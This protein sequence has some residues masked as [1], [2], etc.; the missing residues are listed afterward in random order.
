MK[1]Y[2]RLLKYVTVLT[3]SDESSSTVPSSDCQFHL[4]KLLVEEL[5]ELGVTDAHID[6]QCYVYGHLPATKG[7]ES[8]TSV[9]FIS[10]M[11]TVSDFCDHTITPVITKDYDG[12][13][14][15]LGTSGRVLD[16]KMFP[17]LA[18]LKGRT[19]ITSD[20]TTILGSDDKAGIAEI[21]T[22]L[23]SIIKNQIP[24]GPVSIAFTPDEEIGMGPAHFNVK[25]F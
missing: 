2:E 12:K 11:D 22:A 9:G 16:P 15:T 14:L 8:C 21:M 25:E 1:A 19:L 17:H 5:K 18:S 4:G 24:H 20:G 7:F 23:E 10:H 13:A 6:D 3:P